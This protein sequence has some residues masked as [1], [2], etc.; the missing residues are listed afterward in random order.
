MRILVVS[1]FYPPHHIGGYELGCRDIVNGLRRR[2][3]EI[4]VLTSTYGIG[5]SETSEGVH[6]RLQADLH[7]ER[8][9]FLPCL[10]YVLRKETVNQNAFR[11][12]VRQF[13]PDLIYLWNLTHL[14]M[15]LGYMAERTGLPV[16]YFIFDQWLTL[17]KDLDSWYSI[18][19]RQP[20]YWYSKFG[21]RMLRTSRLTGLDTFD[22]I[23]AN[24]I[25]FGSHYLEELT[26]SSLPIANSRV[27]HWAV[28]GDQFPFSE[29]RREPTRLLYVGQVIA[30]KGVHTAIE[31]F[32]L[33]VQQEPH[34][35]LTL[36]LVGGSVE[37]AYE[38]GLRQRVASLE[39]AQRV[40]FLGHKPR[41]SLSALYRE[42]DILLFPSVWQEPFGITL[43]EAM[44]SG[45]V[46]VSTGT[47]GIPEIVRDQENGLIF[48]P[49]DAAACAAQVR[50]LL[51][52]PLLYARLAQNGRRTLQQNFQLGRMLDA[53]E[54][55][56]DEAVRGAH[57]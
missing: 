30:R 45:L 31:A 51:A 40:Q 20:H 8:R 5:H 12:L 50:R 24:H 57:G 1:N 3:H 17:W 28:D 4:A 41:E 39:L 55:D 19:H 52:D 54:N 33:L 2:G 18:T 15:S 27:I 10:L 36:T 14:S 48:P 16:C 47:G 26:R 25:Q 42:H 34:R 22:C 37:P 29:R 9:G 13:K 23:Q 49:E 21:K 7:V 46:V 44:A 43:L 32:N 53:I 11:R 6:R 38:H 35:Q 56:L